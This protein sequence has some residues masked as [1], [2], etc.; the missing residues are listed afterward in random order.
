MRTFFVFITAAVLGATLG[1]AAH[2]RQAGA[3]PQ[4]LGV[5]D[6]VHLTATPTNTGVSIAASSTSDTRVVEYH[7]FPAQ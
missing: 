7:A 1:D 4:N 6:E 2:T 3:A 5:P